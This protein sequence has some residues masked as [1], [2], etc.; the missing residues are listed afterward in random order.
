MELDARSPYYVMC[1]FLFLKYLQTKS[2]L[3]SPI[4]ESAFLAFLQVF[5]RQEAAMP[6]TQMNFVS[7]NGFSHTTAECVSLTLF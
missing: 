7:Q 6:I 2:V 5:C 3:F 4:A 1:S